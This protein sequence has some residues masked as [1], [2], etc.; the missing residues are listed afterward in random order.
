MLYYYV[1]IATDQETIAFGKTI[2]YTYVFPEK[3][4]PCQAGPHGEAQE[5]VMRQKKWEENMAKRLYYSICE[6]E[7]VRQG[8]QV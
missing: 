6:M 3:G 2:C 7:W 1:N 5:S 4:M 8:K